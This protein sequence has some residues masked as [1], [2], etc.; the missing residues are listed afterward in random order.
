MIDINSN[1]SYR[2]LAGFLYAAMSYVKNTVIIKNHLKKSNIN[3]KLA[4]IAPDFPNGALFI[5]KDKQL[6]ILPLSKD[7]W[8]NKDKWDVKIEGEAITFFNYFMNRLGLV[9]P[10]IFKKLK[11][12]PYLSGSLKLL[13]LLGFIKKC[14]IIFNNNASLSEAMFYKFYNLE[15]MKNIL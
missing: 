5:F 1:I 9:R 13:K 14:S 8:E 7:D 6:Q 4:L 15:R 11:T 3:L 10:I 12:T 2:G